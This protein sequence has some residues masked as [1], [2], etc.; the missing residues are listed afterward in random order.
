MLKLYQITPNSPTRFKWTILRSHVPLSNSL[1]ILTLISLLYHFCGQV[2]EYSVLSLILFKSVEFLLVIYY[3][4]SF[5]S[6]YTF[7]NIKV[8]WVLLYVLLGP[9]LMLKQKD[10]GHFYFILMMSLVIFMFYYSCCFNFM[11]CFNPAAPMWQ[12]CAYTIHQRKVK[13]LQWYKSTKI[14]D[15]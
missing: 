4:D 6:I 2:N 9:H 3:S 14:D 5:W 8:G 10:E 15:E 12:I 11:Y 7:S 1:K 13:F